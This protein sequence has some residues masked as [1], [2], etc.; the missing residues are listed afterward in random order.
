IEC[1]FTE[2]NRENRLFAER[3]DFVEACFL[4]FGIKIAHLDSEVMDLSIGFN[5]PVVD[6]E[7][8]RRHI[9]DTLNKIYVESLHRDALG[10]ILTALGGEAKDLGSLKRLQKVM[11]YFAPAEDAASLIAPFFVLYDLRVAYS[12]LT[13]AATAA[14]IMAK[15]LERLALPIG[16]GLQPIYD[17]LL[18]RMLASYSSMTKLIKPA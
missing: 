2:P 15:V 10:K 8:E 18:D 3:S 1:I 9:A 14:E 16:S 5:P 12:H 11:E 13:S 7:K 4:R 6:T 17:A